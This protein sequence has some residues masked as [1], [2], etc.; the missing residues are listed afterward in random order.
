[1]QNN[2]NSEELRAFCSSARNTEL[3]LV[4]FE[5]ITTDLDEDDK[6]LLK[7]FVTDY[8]WWHGGKEI[9]RG[10]SY[11]SPILALLKLINA[12]SEHV[13]IIV[14]NL[15]EANFDLETQSKYFEILDT[16]DQRFGISSNSQ[17]LS[18]GENIL[19][20]GVPGSGK[21]HKIATKYCN[22]ERRMERLVFH[23]DYMNTDF[24][25]QI[26][27]IVKENGDI[28][29]SF[30]PGPFTRILKKALI[31]PTEHYYLIIEELNRGNAPGIFGE[32]FQLLDRND[33]G[34]SVYGINN[35]V[36]ADNVYG[37]K[38]H[39]IRIPSNLSL[40]ATM[41]TADQNV[42]TLD[43]A[44]QR[45][46]TMEMIENDVDTSKYGG[47]FIADS[48]YTWKAFNKVVNNKI[49]ETSNLTLTSEDKRMGAYFISDKVLNNK[50]V[51]SL[52]TGDDL[53][54]FNKKNKRFAEKVLKYLWDDAF[55]FNRDEVF[56]ISVYSNLEAVIKQFTNN[57]TPNNQRF[58]V[59]AKDIRE[60]LDILRDAS[61]S[62]SGD[63]IGDENADSAE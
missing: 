20:Y 63:I 40:L 21:S 2:L 39:Q 46:W 55:K 62:M 52:P 61:D 48:D 19:L 54:E 29:Y 57:E 34:E 13:A 51:T 41:N 33:N 50:L 12:S 53:K 8:S 59:L 32:V 6:I 25:G 22:D 28:T 27:P 17:R 3:D 42:F 16:S 10:D 45:R 4:T 15:V 23:P 14:K 1:M 37:D 11:I 49:I 47:Y 36:I 9:H 24:V 44:F 43:T 38:E 35:S 18:T 60:E 7:A 5:S 30:S 31:N 56:D 58:D 26:M